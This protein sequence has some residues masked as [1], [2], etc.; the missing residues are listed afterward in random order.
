MVAGAI[1]KEQ[2]LATSKLLVKASEDVRL[3]E[4]V[5]DDGSGNGLVAATAALKADGMTVY[6]STEEHVY[7]TE[8]LAGDD[9]YIVCVE[10]G[11]VEVIKKT[12]NDIKKGSRV[13]V[14]ATAGEADVWAAPASGATYDQAAEQANY[15]IMMGIIGRCTEDCLNAEVTMKILIGVV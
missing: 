11:Y 14:S 2:L 6:M 5:C 3:G 7:A 15:D 12:G 13:I 8:E 4:L 10:V 9:H 1:L